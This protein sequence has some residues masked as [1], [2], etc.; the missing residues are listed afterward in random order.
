MAANGPTIVARFRFE[1]L[2]EIKSAFED[3]RKSFERELGRMKAAGASVGDGIRKGV[4]SAQTSM[5]NIATVGTRSFG[6]IRSAA[7]GLL[8][9]LKSTVSAFATLGRTA[10]GVATKVGTFGVLAVGAVNAFGVSTGK[11][12]DELGR[13]ARAAGVPT[14][15]F[16]RLASATRLLGGD[17]NDLSSGLK[18]LSDK[19]IEAAKDSESGAGKAFRQLGLDVRKSNGDIKSTEEML[20]EVADALARVPSDTL[21]TSAAIDIFG[22]SAANLMPLLEKGAAGIEEYARQADR[23]GTV[24]T[25]AQSKTS[26]ELLVRYRR[27]TEALRGIAYRV[28]EGVLPFLA[29]NSE[30]VADYLTKNSDRI[31]KF[32]TRSV[33]EITGIGSDLVRALTG[34]ADR[35]ERAWVRRLV[36][37]FRIVKETLLDV[38]DMLGG[39]EATRQP[40]INTIRRA[41]V[42]AGQ[43]ALAFGKGVLT[44]MG[45]SEAELPTME[46]L[47]S[48]IESAFTSLRAG[49]EGRKED[50]DMPWAA[51]IGETLMKLGTAFGTIVNI[52]VKNKDEIIK[53]A[54]D[55][56]SLI[57]GLTTA[58]L[59]LVRGDDIPEDNPFHFIQGWKDWLKTKYDEYKED[60]KKF[61]NDF[62]KAWGVVEGVAETLWGW[63]DKISKAFGL[64]NGTQL[65]ILI[66]IAKIAG[67]FGIIE[68]L[69]GLI[70]PAVTALGSALAIPSGLILGIVA[71][72]AALAAAIYYYWDDIAPYAEAIWQAVA[73]G[74]AWMWDRI[75]PIFENVAR[76]AVWMWD[77]LQ[78][79]WDGMKA[80]F[81]VMVAVAQRVWDGLKRVWE[82]LAPFF[83][84]LFE[85]AKRTAELFFQV[86][87]YGPLDAWDAIVGVWDGLPSHFKGIVDTVA[88]HFRSLWD[89]VATG[90]RGAWGKVKSFFG[91]GGEDAPSGGG[92]G[93]PGFASGG[94]V[95][96]AG[97]GVSDSIRAWLSNGE[98]VLTARAVR[99]YGEGLVHMLNNMLLPKDLISGGGLAAAA[100]PAGGSLGSLHLGIGG[101]EVRGSIYGDA[102][103]LRSLR[104][105]FRDQAIASR[106]RLP[107]WRGA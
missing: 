64:E 35:I 95:R 38:F 4:E 16:S 69:L 55:L 75:Q 53:T 9:M 49:I 11:T 85:R 74:A 65:G 50:A 13:M 102:D 45:I 21:R 17:V 97:T 61:T 6:V 80:Y 2:D 48:K 40:W 107:R 46:N 27:V 51:N 83:E 70:T 77:H 12:I 15:R 84:A 66:F 31:T 67:F 5:R 60:V 20:N 96:G 10:L 8:T 44:A 99:H 104:R 23:L 52:I 72:V 42:A 76:H 47:A 103:A 37:V 43:A 24:V 36:P 93:A 7:S 100:A 34:E 14:D 73:D 56:I 54:T 71:A 68:G 33:K 90:A 106:G 1:G 32:V 98:G 25:E 91:F 94:I 19:I 22:G 78:V 86:L 88:G 81:E 39:G 28:A 62:K 63:L 87:T 3:M 92:D 18:D 105:D 82:P 29:E 101:R 89:G 59:A 26:R 79:A 41:F 30:K 58:V 57:G